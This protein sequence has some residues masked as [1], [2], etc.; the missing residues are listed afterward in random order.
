M[1]DFGSN[2][3]VAPAK[4]FPRDQLRAIVE[5]V[6]RLEVEKAGIAFDIKDIYT[7]AKSNGLDVKAL[8]TIVRMRRQDANERAEQEAILD[9]YLQ[10]IGMLA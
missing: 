2:T 1:T 6:E 10:A 3:G 5:R 9:T 4:A 8:R 7:E